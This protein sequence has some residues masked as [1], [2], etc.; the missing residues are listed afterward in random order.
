[1][2]D[3]AF[4]LAEAQM[5]MSTSGHGSTMRGAFSSGYNWGDLY[6]LQGD[7]TVSRADQDN[8]FD[9]AYAVHA[10]YELSSEFTL[11]AFVGIEDAQVGTGV[12]WFHGMEAAIRANNGTIHLY[13]TKNGGS[14]FPAH[15]NVEAGGVAE[16]ILNDRLALVGSGVFR[17]NDDDNHA[18]FFFTGGFDYLLDNGV[19]LTTEVALWEQR[20]NWSIVDS[21]T[22]ISAGFKY[23]LDQ[24]NRLFPQR[25][26]SSVFFGN[27]FASLP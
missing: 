25:N 19:T 2:A 24:N 12:D 6:Q 9:F 13:A 26:S 14:S 15:G 23:D 4:T 7:L 1:M 17:D 21:G 5:N 20:V 18:T 3:D 8:R 22:G 11:G 27:E 16:I 10:G